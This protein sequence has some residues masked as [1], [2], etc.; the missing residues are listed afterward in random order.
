MLFD[1]PAGRNAADRMRVIGQPIRRIDGPLKTTG[2][3]P[4]AYERHDV[5]E[6]QLVGYPLGSAI[7]KGRVVSIDASKAGAAPGV[8]G[9]VTALEHEPIEDLIDYDPVRHF[10]GRDVVHYHQA[11]LWSRRASKMLVPRRIS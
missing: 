4:Y 9:I 3:A 5:A 8:V 1:S 2:T 10:G 11:L 6:G 7:A